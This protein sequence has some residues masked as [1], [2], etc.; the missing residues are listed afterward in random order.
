MSNIVIYTKDDCI[1]CTRAKS[2]LTAKQIPF[3]TVHMPNEISRDDLLAKFPTARTMPI[4]TVD[5]VW[6]GGFDQLV[7]HYEEGKL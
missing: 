2:F 1:F 3:T 4:I 5:E 6:I 7:K